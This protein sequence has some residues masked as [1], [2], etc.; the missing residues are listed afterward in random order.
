M[1]ILRNYGSAQTPSQTSGQTSTGNTV[2]GTSTSTTTTRTSTRN[3][4]SSQGLNINAMVANPLNSILGREIFDFGDYYASSPITTGS[5]NTNTSANTGSNSGNSTG[6]GS[7]G[8][9]GKQV[10]GASV[11]GAAGV[12]TGTTDSLIISLLLSL[13]AAFIYVY[14][15]ETALFKKHEAWMLIRKQRL[16]KN[17]FNFA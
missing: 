12:A 10:A 17:K 13:T 6:N 2:S 9:N 3:F 7:G 14:Y 11:A 16:D 8:G 4:G 5:A 15:T 1:G